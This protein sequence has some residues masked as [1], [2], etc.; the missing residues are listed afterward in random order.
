MSGV[1]CNFGTGRPFG[2]SLDEEDHFC[3]V[4][5]DH[6]LADWNVAFHLTGEGKCAYNHRV[7]SVQVCTHTCIIH[8][9]LAVDG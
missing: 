9:Q 6:H 1:T 2:R 3:T 4:L 7:L 8:V 5:C